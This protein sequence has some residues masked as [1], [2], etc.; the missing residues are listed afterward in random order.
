MNL[1]SELLRLLDAAGESSPQADAP[2][3]WSPVPYGR[4]VAADLDDEPL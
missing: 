3:E 2:P 4:P 1:E